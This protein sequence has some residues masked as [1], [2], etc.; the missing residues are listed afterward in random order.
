[1]HW[2]CW[3]SSSSTLSTQERIERIQEL[4]RELNRQCLYQ[5]EVIRRHQTQGLQ[6]LNQGDEQMAQGEAELQLH[7]Q[8][9]RQALVD[10]YVKTR[11]LL[12]E[13]EHAQSMAL[14]AD[15]LSKASG[16]MKDIILG[17]RL[18]RFCVV[19]NATT[20][21]P[22]L[23]SK[24]SNINPVF[25]LRCKKRRRANGATGRRCGACAQRDQ[26]THAQASNVRIAPN[27]SNAT[28]RLAQGLA[29]GRP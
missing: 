13:I 24:S 10:L 12:R 5:A 14:T 3:G 19:A 17:E 27:V 15:V 18:D 7:A 11:L 2:V 26:V 23:K 22:R 28:S 25:S 9:Q 6:Y 4:V 29:K 8:E 21:G 1:M 16:V 20:Q